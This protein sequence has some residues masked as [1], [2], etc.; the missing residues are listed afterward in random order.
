MRFQVIGRGCGG[1]SV[2]DLTTGLP[3]CEAGEPMTGL[4]F[5][6]A[7]MAADAANAIL[8]HE[9]RPANRSRRL[10]LVSSR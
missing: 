2:I 6:E 8:D 1:W 3:L 4:L 5:S 9:Q 10:R 7:S